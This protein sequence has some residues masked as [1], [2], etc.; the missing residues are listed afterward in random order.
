M[1]FAAGLGEVLCLP[2]PDGSLRA[3]LAGWGT[4]EARR[5]RPLPARGRGREAAGRPLRAGARA[6]SR[7]TPELEALGWLLADYRFGRYRGGKAAAAELVCPDGVDAARV[8]RIAAAAAL[9]QDLI[10]TPAR[11]MGPEALEAAFV[12]LG[13]AGTAPRSR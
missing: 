3:A 10:N 12:A 13:A 4:P 6:A 8:D 9:A 2:A 11:D 5:A 7:S 1:G